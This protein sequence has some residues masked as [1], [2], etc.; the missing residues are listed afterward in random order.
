MP[1]LPS[2]RFIFRASI[3][4]A[5]FAGSLSITPTVSYAHHGPRLAAPPVRS[6]LPATVWAIALKVSPA[7]KVSPATSIS[8][9]ETDTEPVPR[10][11]ARLVYLNWEQPKV[12]K[13]ASVSSGRLIIGERF[14]S[15][16][17][18]GSERQD[19]GADE[20]L[21]T[22]DLLAAVPTGSLAEEGPPT[23]ALALD[24]AAESEI[25]GQKAEAASQAET[26]PTLVGADV[27]ETIAV[28]P[29]PQ[30]ATTLAGGY[31]A[32]AKRRSGS[33]EGGNSNNKR[34]QSSSIT[35]PRAFPGVAVPVV[36]IGRGA[37]S[38]LPTTRGTGSKKPRPVPSSPAGSSSERAISDPP[39]GPDVAAAEP[40]TEVGSVPEPAAPS[41]GS[42][43]G[44]PV[45]TEA[46][47]EKA[48][49]VR[50]PA[51]DPSPTPSSM[52]ACDQA[53][54]TLKGGSE[55]RRDKGRS[56]DTERRR[57]D[58]PGGNGRA[59]DQSGSD[60]AQAGDR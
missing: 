55:N 56:G 27:P 60:E 9:V 16:C 58:G 19:A 35:Q 21:G 44:T 4:A 28:S 32:S 46:G 11:S 48:E 59:G 29:T 10:G 5:I 24:E 33:D 38:P 31:R 3:C 2:V 1:I 50:G 45:P 53:E 41:S 26:A 20:N 13:I 6:D 36:S 42:D 37:R 17:C 7:V 43:A 30:T 49:K 14:R 51:Q 54:T 40:V 23:A 22:R 15:L 34:S 12:Y 18:S 8:R 47:S 39:A 57:G 25:S 52:A